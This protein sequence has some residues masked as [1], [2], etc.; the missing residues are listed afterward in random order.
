MVYSFYL[1]AIAPYFL[2]SKRDILSFENP[3][4]SPKRHKLKGY[5]KC[6]KKRK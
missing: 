2:S 1:G 4:F 3:Q 6:K 5:Q